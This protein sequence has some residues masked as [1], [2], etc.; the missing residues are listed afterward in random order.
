MSRE[1]ILGRVRTVL[2][3]S[4]RT[5]V[6]V[7]AEALAHGAPPSLTSTGEVAITRFRVAAEAKGIDVIDVRDDAGIPAAVATYLGPDL[8][9]H[10][11]RMGSNRLASLDWR[12]CHIDIATGAAMA[13]DRVALSR[14]IA[15][16]AETGTLL[17]ASGPR[18]PAT[19]ALLPETHVIVLERAAIVGTFEHAVTILRARY[20]AALPRSVNL[21]SGASRTGDIGG[22]IVHGA[23]GPRRL[24]VLVVEN[25]Q[26]AARA[27]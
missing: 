3:R 24:A 14:A 8:A 5:A 19:L 17:L 20:G 9:G 22:R 4:D 2:D 12:D 10:P 21:I 13:S 26:G 6:P 16:I 7:R 18:D 1:A 25:K 15:G 27:P 11:L 23:H